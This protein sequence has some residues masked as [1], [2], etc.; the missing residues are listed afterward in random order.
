M[1]GAGAA[2]LTAGR[3]SAVRR[4]LAEEGLEAEVDVAGMKCDIAAVRGDAGMRERLA[5]LAPRIREL[6]F[7]YV[8]LEPVDGANGIEES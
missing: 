2:E 6:G 4:L 3:L 5:A 7:R 1:R 8:A